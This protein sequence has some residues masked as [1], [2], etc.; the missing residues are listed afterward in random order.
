MA[1]LERHNHRLL[2]G[3][4]M[5]HLVKIS[6]GCF[7]LIVIGEILTAFRFLT[8]T[9]IMDYHQIAMGITWDSLS[10]GMQTMTLNFMRSAGLGFLITGIAM[11]FILIV[12][13]RRGDRWSGWALASIVLVQST[14]MIGVICSVRYHTAATPPVAPFAIS[15]ILSLIGFITFRVAHSAVDHE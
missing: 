7:F 4:I 1:G 2:G 8:A 6:F 11:V 9:Q 13:F 3:T 5:K 12:P 10:T 14:I 15:G